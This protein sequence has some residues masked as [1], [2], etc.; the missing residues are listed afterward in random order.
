MYDI[1]RKAVRGYNDSDHSV[2]GKEGEKFTCWFC[3]VYF[4]SL[5]KL[6]SWGVYF[7]SLL[8]FATWLHQEVSRQA[9]WCRTSF[10]SGTAVRNQGFHGSSCLGLDT[11][12]PSTSIM[13]ERRTLAILLGD[14]EINGD[15]NT[16][17]MK[18]KAGKQ[19]NLGN[20]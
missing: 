13:V 15:T 8:V 17:I 2:K 18:P 1:Y 14:D 9:R 11:G 5:A 10:A 6:G 4:F 16:W 7:P 3:L 20:W 12:M 19:I